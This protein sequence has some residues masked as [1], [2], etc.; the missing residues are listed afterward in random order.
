MGVKKDPLFRDLPQT[1]QAKNLKPSRISENSPRP[2]HKSMQPAE[3]PDRLMPR[4]QV[5]M[6]GISKDDR[7]VDIPR[8]NPFDSSLSPHRHKHRRQDIPMRRMKNPRPRPRLRTNRLQLEMKHQTQCS[9]LYLVARASACTPVS[10]GAL[11]G[12]PILAAAAFRR[13]LLSITPKI[14]FL[15]PPPS[16]LYLFHLPQPLT[17]DLYHTVKKPGVSQWTPGT[18]PVNYSSHCRNR[19]AN[20][21]EPASLSAE[22]AVGLMTRIWDPI[23]ADRCKRWFVGTI[24]SLG[25]G[26]PG[27]ATDRLEA[28]DGVQ[29][30][31]RFGK[32]SQ[33]ASMLKF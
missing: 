4:P 18:R 28:A 3:P 22:F 24:V 27:G 10:T 13:R 31:R 11:V 25:R 8:Q 17:T 33:S 15:S 6:I 9:A 12:R 19:Y 14:H 26:G 1:V 2:A 29:A 16:V 30:V 21:G 20:W 32:D 5:K 23:P 7:G